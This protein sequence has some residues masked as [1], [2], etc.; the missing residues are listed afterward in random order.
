MI[1]KLTVLGGGTAGLSA[2]LLIKHSLPFVDVTVIESKEIGIIGVG[3]GSTE[4]WRHL[5]NHV[6]IRADDLVKNTDATYKV[7]IKFTNWHGDDTAYWH[8]LAEWVGRRDSLSGIY[9]IFQKLIGQGKENSSSVWPET[10]KSLHAAPFDTEVN[11]W[12]FDTNKLNSYFHK[13]C[14][15]RGVKFVDDIVND[16]ILDQEGFVKTLVGD[17]NQYDADFF[18]DCS[19]FKRVIA[20]KL[21]AKWIDCKKYLPMN[22]AIAFP[23]E[24]KEDIPSYTESTALSSGWMWRIPTQ[25]R[26]GNGYVYCDDFI[27]DDK[28]LEEAQQQHD[29]EIQV[30]KKIKF[31]AGYVEKFWIKNCVTMG[32]AGM[33]V[34]PL[35]ATSIGSTIQQILGLLSA[36]PYWSKT[37]TVEVDTYNKL[38]NEVAE[39]I[40]SFVQVHYITERRDS[41]FWRW[42]NNELELTDWNQ[43]YLETFKNHLPGLTAFTNDFLMF[44]HMHWLQ[45]M[46]GLRMFKNTEQIN[47]LY[48]T[49]FAERLDP[50][51]KYQTM[52]M[53]KEYLPHR[54]CLE[55]IKYGIDCEFSGYISQT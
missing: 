32:L 17:K 10:K 39:N 18:I 51:Y 1:K 41:E 16:V 53:P 15:D 8:S 54:Q 45:V 44:K 55:N 20:S 29:K 36:L 12:H 43:Q 42:V 28:A 46:W 19:G 50:D 40:I 25:Q 3:E 35:E 33:F 49:H 9:H 21:N 34:E 7:G 37:N 2:A 5:M 47:K 6:G 48:T 13:L 23:T 14:I 24:Y 31:S 27:N 22:S 52:Y 38:F 26:F 30:G 4:H 11:Q